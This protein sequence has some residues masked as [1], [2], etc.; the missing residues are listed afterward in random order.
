MMVGLVGAARRALASL[1][2]TRGQGTAVATGTRARDV[3][4]RPGYLECGTCAFRDLGPQ[5]ASSGTR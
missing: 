1:A 3:T 2:A 5:T 4:A